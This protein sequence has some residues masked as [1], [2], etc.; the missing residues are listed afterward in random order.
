MVTAVAVLPSPCSSRTR[1]RL[2]GDFAPASFVAFF[3]VAMIPPLTSRP[4]GAVRLSS[5]R[6]GLSGLHIRVLVQREADE[7]ERSGGDADERGED[8]AEREQHSDKEECGVTPAR[9]L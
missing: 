7:R 6:H 5:Q 9:H 2:T 1:K 8:A 4:F 3:V